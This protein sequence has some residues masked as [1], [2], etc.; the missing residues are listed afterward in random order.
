MPER[1][2]S[3]SMGMKS[4]RDLASLLREACRLLAEAMPRLRPDTVL[5]SRS[6]ISWS[7]SMPMSLLQDQAE[8]SYSVHHPVVTKR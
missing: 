8:E 3:T 7:A 5:A 1:A 4:S 2:P 6:S